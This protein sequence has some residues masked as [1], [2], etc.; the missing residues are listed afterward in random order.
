MDIDGSGN[1][2]SSGD[3]TATNTIIEDP[4]LTG[5]Y[6]LTFTNSDATSDSWDYDGDIAA[7]TTI[8]AVIRVKSLDTAT[9]DA[10]WDFNIQTTAGRSRFVGNKDEINSEHGGEGTGGVPT[11]A[12]TD[13]GAWHIY[14]ITIEF[15]TG[16]SGEDVCNVWQDGTLII[17]TYSNEDSSSSNFRF[18]DASATITFGSIYDWIIF[19]TDD[20]YTPAEL[21]IPGSLPQ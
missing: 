16:P 14:R 11:Y 7:A 6:L 17:D 8:I 2:F 19:R 13:D 1:G 18:G 9:Y 10:I 21:A 4:D 12:F 20:A 5:N 3:D 15:N